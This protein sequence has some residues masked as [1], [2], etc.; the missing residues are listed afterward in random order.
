MKIAVKRFDVLGLVETFLQKEEGVN[1]TEYVL[2]C[3]NSDGGRRV[4]GSGGVLVHRSLASR[5]GSSIDELIWVEFRRKRRS[6]M[7][8]G[9]VYQKPEG[10]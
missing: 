7:M 10:M 1:M 9:V 8:I 3:W 2:Y 6:K 4:S 5:V